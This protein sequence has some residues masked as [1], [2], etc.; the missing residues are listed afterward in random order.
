MN[1]PLRR[2]RR[3]DSAR[4]RAAEVQGGPCRLDAPRD[5]VN[6]DSTALP[7][8][9]DLRFQDRSRASVHKVRVLIGAARE[10]GPFLWKFIPSLPGVDSC[11]SDLFCSNVR[12]SEEL[13]RANGSEDSD[14]SRLRTLIRDLVDGTTGDPAESVASPVESD[15]NRQDEAD[16]DSLKKPLERLAREE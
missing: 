4:S 14:D 16:S 7:G 6:Q 10:R 9:S 2:A 8:G 12:L 15:S 11:E 5:G 3:R 13:L 1:H